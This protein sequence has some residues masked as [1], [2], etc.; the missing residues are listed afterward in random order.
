M[1]VTIPNLKGGRLAKM[2]VTMR[3]TGL[4]AVDYPVMKKMNMHLR[5]MK[6][7]VKEM[8]HPNTVLSV[9]NALVCGTVPAI[10]GPSKVLALA[11]LQIL[12]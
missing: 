6:A 11:H 4:T 7:K 8:I 12:R 9:H 1:I 2:A 5:T 3:T 10:L